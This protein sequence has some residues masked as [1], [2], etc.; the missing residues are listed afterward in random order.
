MRSGSGG[1]RGHPEKVEG[2]ES[3][4]GMYCTREESIFS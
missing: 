1:V 3:L 4:I 2:V